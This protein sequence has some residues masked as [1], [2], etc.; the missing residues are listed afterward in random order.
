MIR[1]LAL[2]LAVVVLYTLARAQDFEP[3][4][5]CNSPS[6]P[7]LLSSSYGILLQ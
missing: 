7:S 6:G 1:I 2:P 5:Y 4:A 3:R